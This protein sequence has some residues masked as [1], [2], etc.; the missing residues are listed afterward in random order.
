MN[1]ISNLKS[2]LC[3]HSSKLRYNRTQ[4]RVKGK[5]SYT[6]F[7]NKTLLT[8]LIVKDAIF[9]RTTWNATSESLLKITAAN[10]QAQSSDPN[11][12]PTNT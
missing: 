11:S 4:K 7:S 2:Y 5:E 12:Q 1:P 9:Q 8:Q 3:R 6:K 10:S